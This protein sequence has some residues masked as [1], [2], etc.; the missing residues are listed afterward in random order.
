[1]LFQYLRQLKT[2]Q[3]RLINLEDISFGEVEGSSFIKPRAS[4]FIIGVPLLKLILGVAPDADPKAT[5][6]LLL[7]QASFASGLERILIADSQVF[8]ARAVLIQMLSPAEKQ[9]AVYKIKWC[10]KSRGLG[11][12]DVKDCFQ[13][14][15]P[16]LSD[17][18]KNEVRKY[19]STIVLFFKW[20]PYWP[21]YALL[22]TLVSLTRTGTMRMPPW[23][24]PAP[25]AA[26]LLLSSDKI[27]EKIQVFGKI[28]E[29]VVQP[30]L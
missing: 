29:E 21:R 10:L 15:E 25:N 20:V 4:F 12:T 18:A 26:S 5:V 14:P 8:P 6:L 11:E 16:A 19:Y 28:S 27:R 9:G 30:L 22:P 24:P 2:S 17:K 1:M 7:K 3:I 23:S 13:M